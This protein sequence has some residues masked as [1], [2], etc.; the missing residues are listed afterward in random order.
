MHLA[1]LGGTFD[2]PHI[3][4]LVAAETAYRSLGIDV[5]TFLP[6]GRPWQK[7][8]QEVT[9]ADHRWAMTLLAIEGVDYFSADDREVRRDGWTYTIETLEA[10]ENHDVWLVLGADAAAGIP[11]WHR[12]EEVLDRARIAVA[13]RPGV[14]RRRVDEALAPGRFRWLEM[15]EMPVSGTDIRAHAARGGSIRFLVTEAVWRYAG[16]HG[17]YVPGE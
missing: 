7:A 15:P 14:D 5:V 17:L 16:E 6:A 3:A 1:L 13:P 8:G 12:G 9:G 2:P 10:F 11:S 4:H